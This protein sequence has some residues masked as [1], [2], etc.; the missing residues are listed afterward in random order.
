MAEARNKVGC[1]GSI[2]CAIVPKMTEEELHK[3]KIESDKKCTMCG[4]FCALKSGDALK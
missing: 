4:P 3:H 1:K 2:D